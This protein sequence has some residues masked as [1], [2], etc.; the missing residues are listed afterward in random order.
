MRTWMSS[1][2]W[3]SYKPPA[4]FLY[5]PYNDLTCLFVKSRTAVIV[6]PTAQTAKSIVLPKVWSAAPANTEA[7]GIIP[8]DPTLRRLPTLLS[9]F[10]STL[11]CNV[12]LRGILIKES[13]NP[14][15]RHPAQNSSKKAFKET[16]AA[17]NRQYP[18]DRAIITPEKAHNRFETFS[19]HF[20]S[21]SLALII[22]APIRELTPMQTLN[23][24]DHSS[25]FRKLS[26]R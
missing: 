2:G 6:N 8:C 1:Q 5:I 22:T 4:A 3:V 14:I 13:R 7:I 25:G 24:D 17:A 18:T 15:T 12:V 9:L 20:S 23:T 21:C 19:P 10:F 16:P 26:N 11:R